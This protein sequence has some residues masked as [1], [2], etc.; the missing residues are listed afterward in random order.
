MRE[1]IIH[2]D[3]VD[4]TGKD[5]IKDNLI[6]LSN[7]RYMIIVRSYISQIVYSNIYKRDININFFINK[8]IQAYNNGEYFFFLDASTETIIKRFI[9]HNE[10]DLIIDD[11]NKHKKYFYDVIDILKE[12]NIIINIID[13]TFNSIQESCNLILEKLI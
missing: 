6:K 8:M 9:Y 13:T 12:K 3:G 11:I 5:T 4:K 2:L 1:K 10:K 7:G